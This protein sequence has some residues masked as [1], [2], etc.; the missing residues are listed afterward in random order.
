MR[1]MKEQSIWKI[2]ALYA[3]A[4]VDTSKE[5]TFLVWRFSCRFCS[6]KSSDS[7][8]FVLFLEF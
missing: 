1:C 8:F 6:Q 7:I 3:K 2:Y 4:A 5:T